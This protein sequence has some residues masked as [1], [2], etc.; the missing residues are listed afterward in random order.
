MTCVRD[1]AKPWRV[2]FLDELKAY[3]ERVELLARAGKPDLAAH[4]KH[5][6]EALRERERD[7]L[8]ERR[9]R[10]LH[11]VWS[12][13]LAPFCSEL[14]RLLIEGLGSGS[15]PAEL[16][17]LVNVALSRE[18]GLGASTGS[19]VED[20]E[21]DRL[22]LLARDS[23]DEAQSYIPRYCLEIRAVRR[24]GED[25]QRTP[26]GQIFL[27]LPPRDAIRWL[28]ALEV[29]QAWGP[30]DPWRLSRMSAQAI[31]KAGRW[32]EIWNDDGASSRVPAV[33]ET[34]NRLEELGLLMI[35]LRSR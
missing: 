33:D 1:G 22:A 29:T 30:D 18:L 12:E 23:V 26:I 9:L 35:D 32:F 25:L 6:L 17:R 16:T 10:R 5:L 14:S 15:S 13:R 7:G 2:S 8:E 19:A 28:L 21:L 34:L 20:M 24:A 4:R 3:L 27:E 31:L 11:D